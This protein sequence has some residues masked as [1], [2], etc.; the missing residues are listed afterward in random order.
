MAYSKRLKTKR[1]A[2]SRHKGLSAAQV[3]RELEE[4]NRI[5]IALS[6]TRDV[7]RLLDLILQKAREITAAD[8][9]SLY[10]AEQV[11][12]SNDSGNNAPTRTDE[13]RRLAFR[14]TQND[15]VKFPYS[16]Q[17][18]EITESSMAGYCALHGEV[19]ELADAYRIPKSHPF[20][21]NAS[22][23]EQAGYRTRSLIALP[24]KNGKGE[25]LGVLQLINCKRQPKARLT[26][27]AAVRRYVHLFPDRAVRLGLSLASQAAVAYEN[28]RL[29]RDIETLFDGFVNAAVKAI[30]QRDPTTSGHSQ[31]VCAMTVGLA[32]AVDHEHRG[33]YGDLRFSREQMKELRYAALLHDF[34]KVGVREEILVKAKKLY[35][36]QFSCLLERFDYIRRDIEARIAEQK[37]LAL[38]GLF[39]KEPE[40][41]A[42]LKQLE[43]E[44]SRLLAEL[45]RYTEFIIRANEPTLLPSGDF[46]LL[47]EIAQ[48][49]YSDPRCIERPYLTAEEVR[50]LS[51]PRGSLDTDERRQI[52]SH[53]M[54]SFNFLTQI[55][56][57]AEYRR[58]PEIAGAHHEKL[59]GKGYPNGLTSSEIPVQAKMMTICDIFDALTASD[60][61]YK[62]AI[63]TD[64]ALDIL[65]LCVRDEEIDPELFRL[66]LDAQIYGL[67]TKPS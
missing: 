49:T 19:I 50:A 63:P 60:R 35:P 39:R 2:G 41:R 16:E 15:S 65:K 48:K 5:G 13:T 64:R 33:P 46:E 66:F 25:V 43:G 53:V 31:R 38:S 34:G 1:P 7:D 30:E 18:L 51:I 61:P 44:T 59:N 55:P 36:L 14:L 6:E 4:L 40:A 10:L 56:W 52:E 57:T 67:A 27:A 54:H 58:I 26:D 29:Y 8:A 47:N 42:R 32:E 45:D 12:P 24:M 62:R 3:T 20:H 37:V 9:G 23:D 11:C 22:F 17:T 28:S 21:F